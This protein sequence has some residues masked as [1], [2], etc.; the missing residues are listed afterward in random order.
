MRWLIDS[1]FC[2]STYFSPGLLAIDR[3]TQTA[4]KATCTQATGPNWIATKGKRRW[5]VRV[6]TCPRPVFCSHSPALHWSVV[7][8][9]I[10]RC[11]NKMKATTVGWLMLISTS[12]SILIM[13]KHV[14]FKVLLCYL[15]LSACK[16][17]S[18]QLV[19]SQS[20]TIALAVHQSGQALCRS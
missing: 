17:F 20:S 14:L 18:A 6:Y 9:L 11:S 12:V 15:Y 10:K 2:G 16:S 1:L 7:L 3:Q 4:V 13:S 8:R 19:V 5:S